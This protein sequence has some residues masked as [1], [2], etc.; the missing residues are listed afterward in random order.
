M[1]SFGESNPPGICPEGVLACDDG[2]GL[3]AALGAGDG[4]DGE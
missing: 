2:A 1:K 4:L 3:L